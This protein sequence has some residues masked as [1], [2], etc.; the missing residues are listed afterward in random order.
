MSNKCRKIFVVPKIL[1]SSLVHSSL[2]GFT[3]YG[4]ALVSLILPDF[5][6]VLS[7][8]EL[9]SFRSEGRIEYIEKILKRE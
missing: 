1:H 8:C 6:N 7:Q 4:G 9:Q 2:K 5:Q 3:M